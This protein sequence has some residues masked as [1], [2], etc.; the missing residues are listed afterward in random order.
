MKTIKIF[1][2]DDVVAYVG[3]INGNVKYADIGV[4]RGITVLENSD[5]ITILVDFTSDK[6][7]CMVLNPNDLVYLGRLER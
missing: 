1:E 5:D 4:V 3:D 7:V 6:E 2:K